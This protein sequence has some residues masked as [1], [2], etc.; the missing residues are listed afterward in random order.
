MARPDAT[1]PPWR[2]EAD[3]PA[4][5]GPDGRSLGTVIRDARGRR[6]L[7]LCPPG[8]GGTA[9]VQAAAAAAAM[10]ALANGAVAAVETGPRRPST[11]RARQEDANV[12]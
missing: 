4:C 3:A 5:F 9:A 1:E 6:V 12:V 8:T 7:R 10:V 11:R 2:A